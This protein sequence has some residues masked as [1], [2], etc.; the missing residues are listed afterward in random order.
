VD[1]LV[2]CFCGCVE[3]E[4]VVGG[5]GVCVGGVGTL[6][7]WEDAIGV[8]V[9][10]LFIEHYACVSLVLWS[11]NLKLFTIEIGLWL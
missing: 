10:F 8:I 1:G 11:N 7:F 6:A 2:G 5:F 4:G 3:V 9:D